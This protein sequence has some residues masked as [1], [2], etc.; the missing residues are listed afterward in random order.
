M[1]KN[2]KHN[3]F[4]KTLVQVG[5]E[6]MPFIALFGLLFIFHLNAIPTNDDLTEI[7]KY[8]DF[9][10][11]LKGIWMRYN[12]WSSRSLYTGFWYYFVNHY[13]AY[14]VVDS[15]LMTLIPLMLYKMSGDHRP[16]TAW[17]AVY[18]FLIYRLYN[19]SSAGWAGTTISYIFPSAFALVGMYGFVK[20]LRNLPFKPWEYPLYLSSIFIGANLETVSAAML[21]VFILGF[22]WWRITSNDKKNYFG[23]YIYYII[24]LVFILLNLIWHLFSPGNANR[25]LFE[26]RWFP[27]F[28]TL[29]IFRKMMLGG[30]NTLYDLFFNGN[31]LPLMCCILLCVI[32]FKRH[33][34]IM[35]KIISLVPIVFSGIV[36]FRLLEIGLGKL[37]NVRPVA[38]IILFGTWKTSDF[39]NI[40][41]IDTTNY[42][43]YKPL[44]AYTVIAVIFC[45][46]ITSFF[47]AFPVKKATIY[48]IILFSGLAT[49]VVM[50]FSPTIWASGSRAHFFGEV[51]LMVIFTLLYSD[52]TG[53][54][55]S[56]KG[57]GKNGLFQFGMLLLGLTFFF[58][59]YYISFDHELRE[60]IVFLLF[61]VILFASY[62]SQYATLGLK[63]IILFICVTSIFL[64]ILP[65]VS[66]IVNPLATTTLGTHDYQISPT[67]A[68]PLQNSTCV[69]E[70]EIKAEYD[71]L[72]KISFLIGTY[73]RVNSN[74]I[75]IK[76]VDEN[77]RII[78]EKT[79]DASKLIDNAQYDFTFDRMGNSEGKIYKLRITSP[80]ADDEN[81]EA[82]WGCENL[83]MFNNLYIND[84]LSAQKIAMKILYN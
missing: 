76:L 84:Q 1:V 67:V 81:F 59:V 42:F 53:D 10:G 31:F 57:I 4:F 66:K 24:S 15:M 28:Q 9:F 49:S 3:S 36:G 77:D 39:F 58:A 75:N 13:Y 46:F 8:N 73:S 18:I 27:G 19:M 50:G 54:F 34:Q 2:L 74:Q 72:Y 80:D 6:Y 11:I 63:K 43:S 62:F 64:L 51:T 12:T 16:T 45:C 70:Q 14:K 48:I 22:I 25:S 47:L 23:S 78:E 44:L 69:F 65:P 82:I 5:I 32:V 35:P 33:K 20:F 30:V 21:L 52:F 17:A 29:S 83:E 68:L 26:L 55:E 71:G 41:L 60:Y 38:D 7:G 61:T 79:I 37:N 40:G 56:H